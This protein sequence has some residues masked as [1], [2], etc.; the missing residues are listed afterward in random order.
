[1]AVWAGALLKTRSHHLV[2]NSTNL[3]LYSTEPPIVRFYLRIPLRLRLCVPR[4]LSISPESWFLRFFFLSPESGCFQFWCKL[5]MDHEPYD[6]SG[7]DDDFPPTHQNRIPRGAHLAGNGSAVGSIPYARMYGEIDMETQIHQ[8][9]KE[10]YSSVLRAFKAQADVITWE[11]ESLTTELRKEL[12]LSNEELRELLGHVNADDVIQNIREWR[13]AGGNQLGVLSFGQAIHDSIP[14]PPI[15]ASRKKQKITPSALSQSFGG[16]SPF[17]PQSV[18]APVQ[19]SL[20]EKRGPVSGS[21][22]KKHK[23]GHALPGVSSIKQYPSSG[24][25]GRNQ[26]PN[27]VTSGTVMGELA[28]GASL[29]SLVGRR[30]RTRWPDDNNFYEAVISDYNRSEGLHALFYDLGTANESWEWVNLSEMSPADIQW[31]GEDPGVNRRQG[32]G[33]SGNGMRRSVGRGSVPGVGKG[34][35][36]AKGQSRKDFLP[37]QNGIGM[38]TPDDIQILHT[39][40]LVKEVERVFNAKHPDALEIEQ[41][42]KVLKDHEQ[43]LIDAIARLA[44]LSDGESD[45]GGFHFSHATAMAH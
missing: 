4:T 33:G 7:T 17:H 28:E 10:A 37:S 15:S 43:A 41:V 13:Q 6:S 19:S 39:D 9:E 3:R 2:S 36:T 27:R 35:G 30:V 24:L 26:V 31:V 16:P 12:R 11:K 18:D 38:K 32:F 1:M 40:T 23:P 34:R 42:K 22:G 44:D 25:G 45:E 20:V 8:L 14:S 21:K 5:A 29:D